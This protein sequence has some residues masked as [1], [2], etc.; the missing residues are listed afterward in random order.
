M[1]GVQPKRSMD[2]HAAQRWLLHLD[3]QVGYV[4]MHGKAC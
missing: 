4:P 1:H 3:G 2:Y